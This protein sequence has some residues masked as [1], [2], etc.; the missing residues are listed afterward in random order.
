MLLNGRSIGELE[1]TT[2]P[3]KQHIVLPGGVLFR[4]DNEL[5]FLA[6][7]PGVRLHELRLRAAR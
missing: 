3:S 5:R 4:G 6:D 2:E 1:L 7:A